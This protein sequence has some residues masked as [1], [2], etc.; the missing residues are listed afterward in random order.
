MRFF[1]FHRTIKIRIL[2]SFLSTA[3]GNMIFPFMAIYYSAHFGVNR[4]GTFLLI[5][6]MIGIVTSFLGGYLSDSYGRKRVIVLAEVLRFFAFFTMM[7]C[8][9]PWFLSPT[10]TFYMMTIHSICSALSVPATQAMLIEASEPDERKWMYSIMYWA[11]NL[12]IAIGSVLGG[13]LFK[14]YLFELLIALSAASLVTCNLIIFFIKESEESFAVNQAEKGRNLKGH[15]IQLFTN[16]RNVFSDKVFMWYVFAG[17]L[18]LS[19]EFQLGNYISIRFAQEIP[20]QSLFGWRIG[21][22]ELTGLLRTENTLLVVTLALFAAKLMQRF[23]DRQVIVVSWAVFI[24]GYAITSYA[25]NLWLLVTV[26]VVIS[27]SEVMRVPVEQ[28]YLAQLPPEHARASYLAVSGMRN[29]LAML[30]SA[31]TVIISTFLDKLGT[32]LWIAILGGIG[33][34]LFICIAPVLDKRV[35]LDQEGGHK[36]AVSAE[37]AN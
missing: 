24:T 22:I 32:T 13:L 23:N 17:I 16:Y 34:I 36:K 3:I 21:G 5:N 12:S 15:I 10:V 8:N 25:N 1:N 27:V 20:E 35:K 31:V 19:T 9:S 30:V 26:M 29:N 7:V 37:T 6:I 4:A 28:S 11:S 14:N 18:V 33:L 2:E